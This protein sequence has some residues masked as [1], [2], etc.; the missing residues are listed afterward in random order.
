MDISTS[1]LVLAAASG[2][3]SELVYV[4]DVFSTDLY[5]GSS[6][7]HTITNG[8]DLSG[9]GG[10]V[11]I[12]NRDNARKHSLYDSERPLSNR[13]S[14]NES[15]G[16]QTLGASGTLT[17]NSNG[18][19]IPS[20]D[21]DLNGNGFGSQVAWSFRKAPGFFDVVTYTGDGTNGRQIPHALG[22]T[23]GMVI[24]KRTNGID[25]WTVQHRSL[26]GTKSLYLNLS[27]PEDVSVTEWNNTSATSTVFTVGTSGKTN[28]INDTYVAYI[29]AHNDAQFGTDGDE[30]IIKCGSYTGNINNQVIDLGFEPQWVLVK[31]SSDYQSWFLFDSMRGMSGSANSSNYFFP[32]SNNADNIHD[33]MQARENGFQLIGSGAGPNDHG[34][35][36]YMAIRRPN[37]PPETATDVFYTTYNYNDAHYTVAGFPVDFAITANRDHTY[38]NIVGSRLHGRNY[39]YSALTSWR[40]PS[41]YADT[42][43]SNTSFRF[44]YAGSGYGWANFAFKRAPGFM[45][46]LLYDGNGN[47]NLQVSHNL[48]VKP[49]MIIIKNTT[50][51]SGTN[52][53]L[54]HKDIFNTQLSL[55]RPDPWANGGPSST[56]GGSGSG[57][58]TGASLLSSTSS[59]ILPGNAFLENAASE[60]YSAFLFATLPGISKVGSYTGTGSDMDIDCG[61]T[62]GARFVM[63]K[64][65]DSTADWFVWD[66]VRGITSGNDPY[67]KLNQRETEKTNTN[68]ID[69]Y[70]SGFRANANDADI[71]TNGGFYIFLAIA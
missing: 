43:T 22:S 61:F 16:E 19:S 54:W 68:H 4:D 24:V 25:N 12:K 65:A 59:Y 27:N 36:I 70:N 38:G 41:G 52:W 17:F 32:N 31:K 53:T 28:A 63:I 42:W 58:A 67:I 48:E 13:L 69:P 8:I 9:Q 3:A 30:S 45:D 50:Y 56:Y 29:F 5:E 44:V 39:L 40:D 2:G 66:S 7:T 33:Y 1:K 14:S 26:G 35:Y 64:R 46:V 6:S 11:W 15:A 57:T 47:A 23:P 18:V 37:K 34:T 10:L 51:S 55:N 49:E 71:N 20:G 60:K 21:G 62:N